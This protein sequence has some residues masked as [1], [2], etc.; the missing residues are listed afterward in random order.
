MNPAARTISP[1]SHCAGLRYGLLGLPLAFVALPLY[2]HLPNVYASRYGMPLATLGA[3]LLLARLLDAVTDPWLGHLSDRLQA[4][5]PRHVLLAAS[6]AALLLVL[7]VALLFFP[8]WR[9]PD[10]PVAL[11]GVLALTFLAL[12]LL[13]I[14]HQS[15][16]GAAWRRRGAACPHRCLAR[17]CRLA[18]RGAG[19]GA[20]LMAGPVH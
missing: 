5:S 9:Q 4:R 15:W 20:A 16:G 19:L 10:D 3:V 1:A 18:G 14:A 11:L 17:G 6:L 12:S 8:P 13:A 7:G 2:V